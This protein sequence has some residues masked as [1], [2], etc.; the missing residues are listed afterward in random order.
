VANIIEGQER[1]VEDHQL[2]RSLL[3]CVITHKA[4]L[5]YFGLNVTICANEALRSLETTA[6]KV[7][8][9]TGL[10]VEL[11]RVKSRRQGCFKIVEFGRRLL[12]LAH[13]AFHFAR[14]FKLT[15]VPGW[16]DPSSLS[17]PTPESFAAE[18]Y[19]NSHH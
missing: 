4:V 15:S 2:A 19:R 16:S 3:V 1:Q 18:A 5:S 7:T 12:S 9:V 13:R 8:N 6:T 10:R 11:S 17:L 14:Y